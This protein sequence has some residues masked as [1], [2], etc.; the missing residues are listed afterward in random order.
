VGVAPSTA[1]LLDVTVTLWGRG[2]VLVKSIV[3]LPAFADSEVVSNFRAPPGSAASFNAPP[4]EAAGAGVEAV[5]LEVVAGGAAVEE[6]VVLLE[7]LDPHPASTT[8][9]NSP[10]TKVRFM[11]QLRWLTVH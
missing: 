11:W 2:E 10:A 3:T 6:D 9:A 5:A 7:L 4:D 8:S 1:P